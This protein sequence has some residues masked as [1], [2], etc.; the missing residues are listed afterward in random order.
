MKTPLILSICAALFSI[1]AYSQTDFTGS[2][3]IT[4]Q[5]NNK[6]INEIWLGAEGGDWGGKTF[7]SLAACTPAQTSAYIS[8]GTSVGY[9]DLFST[10]L[11]AAVAGKKVSFYGYC[12]KQGAASGVFDVTHIIVAH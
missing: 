9:E 1:S 8:K 10:M 4:S 5:I 11:A 2:H 7:G 6:N 12:N 3:L